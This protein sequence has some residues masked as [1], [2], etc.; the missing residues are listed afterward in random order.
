MKITLEGTHEEIVATVQALVVSEIVTAV[1]G[2]TLQRLT[3]IVPPKLAA[4]SEQEGGA[5]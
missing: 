3:A 1:D 5:K 4:G 2:E